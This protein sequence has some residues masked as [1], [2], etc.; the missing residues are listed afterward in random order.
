MAGAVLP[1]AAGG[2]AVNLVSLAG[3]GLLTKSK[4]ARSTFPQFRRA[5]GG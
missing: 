1:S 5:T 4:P 2:P 3:G